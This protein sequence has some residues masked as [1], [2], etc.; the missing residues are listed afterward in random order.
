MKKNV[1]R[2]FACLFAALILIGSTA[3]TAL[4][5]NRNV[6][7]G[8]FGTKSYTV[9]TDTEGGE[10]YSTFVAD[11]ADTTELVAANE[12]IGEALLEE[13]AVLLKNEDALPLPENARSVTLLGLRADAK[14]LYG[15][16]IGVSVPSAQNVSLTQALEDKGFAVNETA[17][18]VYKTLDG[19][20]DYKKLNKFSA[21]FSGVPVDGEPQYVVAEPTAEEL[22]ATDGSF[23]ESLEK[24]H[25]AAIVVLGRP[26]SEAGDYYPGATGIDPSY[27]ARN[28]L[29]LTDA[30][31]A[32]VSFAGDHFETVIV[33]INA[34]NTMEIRELEE[35]PNVSAILW[36]GL[37]GN[38]GMRGVVDILTGEVNPSGALPDLYASDTTSAPAMANFGVIAWDNAGDYLDTAV[39]RGDY[40]LIEAEGIYTGYRYYETRYADTVM[41]RGNADSEVGAFDSAAGWNYDEEVVYPFGYGLSYTTFSKTLE[42]VDV[43]VKGNTA[44][45]AVTVKNTGNAAGKT[46]VQL[47]A[48][49]PYIE[50]GVE[51]SAIVL[52]DYGKTS[53]LQ[54]G[55]SVS[56]TITADLQNLSSYDDAES[57]TFIL[58]AGDYYFTIA[59]GSH[60]AVNNVLKAQGFDAAGNADNVKSWAY[61]PDGGKD[62]TTYAIT[63]SG[64]KVSNHLGDA[65]YNTWVPGT[66][67]YLSRSDWAGTWPKTYDS[68]TLP[69]E[70]LPYLKNDFY[71]IAE[72]DDVSEILFNKKSENGLS[73]SDMK[74]AEYDDPRW[75]ELLNQLDLQEAILFITKGNRNAPAME[76]IGFSGGQYTENGPN[77][78]NAKLAAYSDD[79]SPWYVTAEDPNAE[80]Q[81]NNMGCAPL[82][83]ATFN[84]EFSEECGILWGNNSLFNGL[85]FIWGPGLNLHRHA[86]N[87]RNCEYYSEDPVLS[88]YTGLA[89]ARG[90]LTKGLICAPKHYAFN[91]QESNR[92]GVAPFMNEQKAR[93]LELRSFQIAIEGGTLGVMTSFSRI[94][95]VYVG[96]HKGL[97]QDILCDEWGFH[98]YVISDMVNPASYMTWKE[99]VIAGTTNFDTNDVQELWNAYITETTNTLLHDA[100]MLKAI[101]DRVHNT[102]YVYAQSNAMNG[103]NS[104]SH[105]VELNVWWRTLYKTLLYGSAALTAICVLGYT[106]SSVAGA[107][108]RKENQA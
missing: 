16:T 25:D 108:K 32:L 59:D 6:V 7:D 12:A 106:V 26:G 14:T 94:G 66:V 57:E 98:G 95:P 53:V 23:M 73:F 69:E 58:D 15:A 33:L 47:Y 46:P 45:A 13:G 78:F 79:A 20:A 107:K 31:R 68:L 80:Y 43:D 3:G 93:E 55:E 52:L 29:A 90:A 64:V 24:Y 101:K 1:W 81:G 82:L 100:E 87:G 38:Y 99:S 97:I 84:K 61:D 49:A 71:A 37:P 103:I 67:T 22:E 28:P 10:L 70:M 102:L 85:P 60:E 18:A 36:I 39:D 35:D 63:K 44:I 41:G 88:G 56:V 30:E 89:V 42:S 65:D 5:A 11:Y 17:N 9:V 105:R 62:A 86:Y 91:D 21:S 104:S 34:A 92:N 54:P 96:A 72:N 50:G 2:G 83:A 77:G 27:G 51:K 40:Y 76:S 8:F 48:Q 74:G 75:E 19:S 4:E